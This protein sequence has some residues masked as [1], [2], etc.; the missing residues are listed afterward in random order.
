MSLPYYKLPYKYEKHIDIYGLNE[1][2]FG[3][4][5]F[6]CWWRLVESSLK[7]TNIIATRSIQNM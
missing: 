4:K 1:H 5:V 7:A 3:E 6:D 2:D